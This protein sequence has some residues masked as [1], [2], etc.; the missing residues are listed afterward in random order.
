MAFHKSDT[1][2]EETSEGG[3]E[4]RTAAMRVTEQRLKS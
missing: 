4:R 1:Q 3:R 2:I